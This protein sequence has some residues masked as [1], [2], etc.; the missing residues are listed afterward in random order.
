MLNRF[1]LIRS[2]DLLKEGSCHSS[3]S[4]HVPIG[5]CLLIKVSF[6]VMYSLVWS[7]GQQRVILV[8]RSRVSH[9]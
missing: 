7:R 4:C 5:L 9:V 3:P 6:K 8:I 2:I 1:H